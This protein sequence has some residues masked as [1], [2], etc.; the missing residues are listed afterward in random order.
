MASAKKRLG[1]GLG[2]LISGAAPAKK[3]PPP[4]KK[5]APSA[6]TT[7]ETAPAP[8]ATP[9]A[10][11]APGFRD[12]EIGL[13]Q[14]NPYQPRKEFKPEQIE[15]LAESIQAEGLIQPIV[16]RPAKDHYELI[17]GERRW[18]AFQHLK[19]KKIPAHIMNVSDVSSATLSLIENL[20]RE[21][22]NPIEEALG[23]AS[24][25]KDFSLTQDAV[26]ER[27]GK[28]RATI[29]N[30]LRLLQL[31]KEIQGYLRKGLLSTGHAKA[32]LSLEEP[33]QRT[34]LARR[35]IENG[36]SVREAENWVKQSKDPRKSGTSS[37]TSS[38]DDA[39]IQDLERRISN[40]LNTGVTLKH[41]PKKGK[42]IIEYYGNEDLQRL[43]DKFG[44]KE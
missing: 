24:L 23:V 22:L 28:A 19:L 32:L 5:S 14:P 16:V 36:M 7:P 9:P 26:S 42:I 10:F 38:A 41:T 11:D 34:I 44:V 39:V 43:L 27:L 25:I 4:A 35:V 15:E 18:R 20:Q 3:S 33:E 21:G 6:K 1:R 31:N 12:I 30:S 40:T 17:A 37:Q 29:A 2:S 8:A 13:I